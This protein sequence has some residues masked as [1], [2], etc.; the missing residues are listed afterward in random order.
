MA[1]PSYDDGN[2]FAKI[3]RGEIPCYK[4]FETEHCIAFL[5]AFPSAPGHSLLVPKKGGFSVL[6]DSKDIMT[7]SMLRCACDAHITPQPHLP[8]YVPHRIG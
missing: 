2:I 4:I 8:T 6:E 1:F 7:C 3:I 5:D